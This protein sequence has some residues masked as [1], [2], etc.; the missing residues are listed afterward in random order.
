LSLNKRLTLGRVGIF[1]LGLKLSSIMM[2]T[3][4]ALFMYLERH[5]LTSNINFEFGMGFGVKCVERVRVV[6]GKKSKR[7]I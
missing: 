5:C 6:W 1:I 2:V 3:E 4:W 7:V